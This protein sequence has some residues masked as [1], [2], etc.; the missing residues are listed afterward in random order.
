[1]LFQIT[2]PFSIQSI[3]NVRTKKKYVRTQ[4]PARLE[5]GQLH[6]INNFLLEVQVTIHWETQLI[7]KAKMLL[8]V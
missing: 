6:S 3:L 4:P 7:A 5:H 2:C 8:R 1:M